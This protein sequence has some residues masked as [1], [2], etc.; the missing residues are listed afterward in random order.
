MERDA[1]WRDFEIEDKPD[2]ITG[3]Y[4]RMKI[5]HKPSGFAVQV[6]GFGYYDTKR[7]GMRKL[8]EILRE[9]D[10]IL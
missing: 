2:N 1:D 4:H 10:V 5:S 6:G 8:K 3:G 7:K 9:N